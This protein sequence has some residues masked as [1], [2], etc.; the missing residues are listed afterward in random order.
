M[1]IQTE[2]TPNPETLKFIPGQPVFPEGTAHFT[3]IDEAAQAPLAKRLLQM[4]EVEVVFY[5]ADFISV[6]K[7]KETDWDQLKTAIMAEI[8]DHFMAGLPAVDEGFGQNNN[9]Q[10][11]DEISGQ[12]KELLRT[13]VK[14]AVAQDGGNIEFVKFDHGSGVVYLSMEGACA[15]CPSSTMTLKSGVENLLKHYIPEVTEVSAVNA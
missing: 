5:G 3:S 1:F 9:D 14:P 2:H 8:M 13:H 11:D 4:E 6:T 7:T 12:I 15:G 10:P